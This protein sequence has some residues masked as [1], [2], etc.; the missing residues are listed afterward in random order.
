MFYLQAAFNL[1]ELNFN[2][3]FINSA[4][5]SGRHEDS[6]GMV[7]ADE[8]PKEHSDKSLSA[9]PEETKYLERKSSGNS[10]KLSSTYTDAL[11]FINSQRL[12]FSPMLN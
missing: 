11:L 7:R 1:N 6:F 2:I 4:E 9:R 10:K 3:S 5:W 12:L 8:K